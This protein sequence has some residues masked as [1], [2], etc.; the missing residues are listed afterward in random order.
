MRFKPSFTDSTISYIHELT[1][2]NVSLPLKSLDDPL[3]LRR[4]TL[5]ISIH[6]ENLTVR[7]GNI[8]PPYHLAALEEFREQCNIYRQMDMF[9]MD[10][11]ILQDMG[12]SKELIIEEVTEYYKSVNQ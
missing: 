5:A 8:L 10:I 3:M 2:H 11:E 12:V 1:K 9:L 4:A 7:E 6:Q